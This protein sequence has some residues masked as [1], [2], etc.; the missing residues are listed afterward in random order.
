M[1][2]SDWSSDVCSSDL[3]FLKD[4]FVLVDY[5][6]SGPTGQR[7]FVGRIAIDGEERSVSGRGNGLISSVVVAL[8]DACGVALDVADYNEHAL[9]QG[10]DRKSVVSGKSV[11]V[12]VALGGRRILKKKTQSK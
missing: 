8:R 4:R 2:I 12:R 1:R 6:E 3:A 11:S 5:E 7:T 9:G 10:S